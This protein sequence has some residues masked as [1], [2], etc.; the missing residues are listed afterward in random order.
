[1]R[2]TRSGPLRNVYKLIF[3]DYNIIKYQFRGGVAGVAESQES[4]FTTLLFFRIRGFRLAFIILFTATDVGQTVYNVSLT[5][6]KNCYRIK[7]LKIVLF[8][9][10]CNWCLYHNKYRWTCLWGSSWLYDWYI[11][12][13][14]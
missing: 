14:K 4:T 8:L 5:L 1:M 13:R 6:F 11:S 2:K 9:K 12:I 3:N 7:H 10:V